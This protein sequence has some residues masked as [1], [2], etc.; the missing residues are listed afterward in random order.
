MGQAWVWAWQRSK[1][2]SGPGP[3]GLCAHGGG[4]GRRA[5]GKPSLGGPTGGAGEGGE[6]FQGARSTELRTR[7]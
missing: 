7:P 2:C 3:R 4:A 5:W 1:G 6:R